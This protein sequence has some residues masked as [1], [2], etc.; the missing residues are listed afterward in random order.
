LRSLDVL[1]AAALAVGLA[2]NGGGSAIAEPLPEPPSPR[3]EP[4]HVPQP[5]SK[6]ERGLWMEMAD[7]EKQLAAS[8]MLVRDP[9]INNFMRDVFCRVAGDYCHDVRI[10][11][12]R[13]PG[14]NASMAPNGMMML[15]TGVFMRVSDEDGLAVVLG[16]ELAHFLRT[17]SLLAW[18][19][20]RREMA[21]G[22][23]LSLVVG[24]ATGV[25]LPVGESLALLSSLSFS[26]EHEREADLLGTKLLVDGGFDPH[27]AY[28]IWE[29]LVEEERRAVAKSEEPG[30]FSQT[31]PEPLERAQELKRYVTERYGPPVERTAAEADYLAGLSRHYEV[32]MEDQLD[33]NRFGRTEFLLER[34]AAMGLD[35]ALVDFYRGEMYR[36]RGGEGDLDAARDAY[37]RSI[38]RENPYPPAC[39]NLGYL[40]L[41]AGD[42]AAAHGYFEQYLALAP[43]ADDREMIKFYLE[44]LP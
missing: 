7:F 36:Q 12:V 31:H 21:A 5:E 27:A 35:P 6:D 25:L 44:D 41:K 42:V 28:E 2:A 3:I 14:F 20:A 18:R 1:A 43:E 9:E 30:V 13:N 23:I 32:L 17:H 19:K 37:L 29:S 34:H 38:A 11:I 39:R 24:V 22:S 16:H 15:W 10:Y 33:T 26:R 8:P 4:G 40:A